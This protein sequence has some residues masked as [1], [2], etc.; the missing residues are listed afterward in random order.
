RR[1][2]SGGAHIGS[3]IFRIVAWTV[4]PIAICLAVLAGPV[5]A[6]V[7]GN[8]W[9]AVV[10]LLP[11]AMAWGVGAS[12]SY[13]GYMLLLSRQQQR[14]CLFADAFFLCGTGVALAVALT[15]V[16]RSYVMASAFCKFVARLLMLQWL[17]RIGSVARDGLVSGFLPPVVAGFLATAAA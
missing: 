17:Y 9:I 13:A 7:Y 11:W 5:I 8:K 14:R 1:G 16:F 15:F 10:P 2:S 12:L 6:T 4:V 3:M